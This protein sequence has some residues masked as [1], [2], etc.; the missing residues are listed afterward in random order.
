MGGGKPQA[1]P[2]QDAL[3]APPPDVLAP[4]HEAAM[5]G[6]MRMLRQL[7]E[8]LGAQ[9]ERWTGFGQTVVRMA[10][11]F[12]SQAVLALIETHMETRP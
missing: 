10:R 11:A 4:L 12:Q 6:N 1:A 5:A 9:D 2:A 3:V 8:G 7:A